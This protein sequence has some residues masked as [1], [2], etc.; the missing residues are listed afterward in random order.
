MPDQDALDLLASM[1]YP[2]A[3]YKETPE[4][5]YSTTVDTG[6]IGPVEPQ[7]AAAAA[8]YTGAGAPT[9]PAPTVTNKIPAEV[10]EVDWKDDIGGAFKGIYDWLGDP[11][12]SATR[13]PPAIGSIPF[14]FYGGVKGSVM[15]LATILPLMLLMG[16]KMDMKKILLLVMMGGLGG[17]I[18]GLFGGGSSTASPVSFDQPSGQ[19]DPMM[20]MLLM[21]GSGSS[22]NKLL[23]TMMMAPMLGIDPM[24]AMMLGQ[25][26]NTGSGRRSYRRRGYSAASRRSYS[27]GLN[28]GAA[29]A[30]LV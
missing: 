2:T 3:W 19:M 22:S 9:G 4:Q 25:F 13:I 20:M 29:R 26:T 5:Q 27:A 16:G 7:K 6:M 15:N 30:R 10:L 21:G 23:T 8:F 17:A 28:A 12:P 14:D 11:F 1:G 18:G 24:A